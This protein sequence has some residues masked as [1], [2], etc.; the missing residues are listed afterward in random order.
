M[1]LITGP[2]TNSGEHHWW[3]KE[4]GVSTL[5]ND[6]KS[7]LPSLTL[8]RLVYLMG[9]CLLSE[10]SLSSPSVF[11]FRLSVSFSL[12][13]GGTVWLRTLLGMSGSRTCSWYHK[14]PS[15][16]GRRQ[17]GSQFWR[18]KGSLWR[19]EGETSQTAGENKSFKAGLAEEVLL[20]ST[21]FTQLYVT[22]VDGMRVRTLV[23]LQKPWS[24]LQCPLI[25]VIWQPTVNEEAHTD[26]PVPCHCY[27]WR[28]CD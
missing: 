7:S 22:K 4:I 26:F 5:T 18:A 10:N 12:K 3:P 24:A 21:G 28:W 17:P 14:S 13:K 27:H 19:P 8:S 16:T 9:A 23:I 1:F 11:E 20:C 15:Q 25:K 6:S 2:S